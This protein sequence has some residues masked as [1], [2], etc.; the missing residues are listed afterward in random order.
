MVALGIHMGSVI[1]ASE[2][3][4]FKDDLKI[5][6]KSEARNSLYLVSMRSFI[7][8]VG[9]IRFLHGQIEFQFC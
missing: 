6:N 4:E 3:F 7:P 1:Q 8:G 2:K 9:K 5:G